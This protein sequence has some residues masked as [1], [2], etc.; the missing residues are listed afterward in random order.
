MNGMETSY[1]FSINVGSD[2]GADCN[3]EFHENI[4]LAA[5]KLKKYPVS[6]EQQEIS[7]KQLV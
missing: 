3:G 4:Q 5:N 2:S 7:T 1:I 6:E